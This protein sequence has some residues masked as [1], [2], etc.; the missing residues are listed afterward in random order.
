MKNF[1]RLFI[2]ACVAAVLA[3]SAVANAAPAKGGHVNTDQPSLFQTG[4]VMAG[5][6]FLGYWG[7]GLDITGSYFFTD[8]IA[9]QVDIAP[10]TYTPVPGFSGNVTYI[11]LMAVY[12][13]AFADN[14]GG[15]FGAGLGMGSATIGGITYSVSG[16]A[17]TV[18]AEMLFSDNI[19]GNI[20]I[21]SGGLNAGISMIF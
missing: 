20:G 15:Y 11:D 2:V 18:G 4:D 21:T 8:N 16:F 7:G 9:A 12:H 13:L 14:M 6:G 19:R 1:S 3:F 10:I 17:Y 5:V